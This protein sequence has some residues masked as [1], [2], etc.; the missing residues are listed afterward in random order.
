MQVGIVALGSVLALL[1]LFGCGAGQG[2]G[3]SGGGG[4]DGDPWG[5]PC[6]PFEEQWPSFSGY[7]V[8]QVTVLESDP[9][10]GTGVCL[11]N[12]F[13]GRVSCPYGQSLADLSLPPDDPRRCRIPDAAGWATEG[14]VE[15]EALPQ[16]LDR[17]AEDVV[18]CSCRCAGPDPSADYC[19]CPSGMECVEVA[20]DL[21]FQRGYEGSYCIAAGTTY[22]SSAVGTITCDK[23]D[24]DPATLCGK[25]RSNP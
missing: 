22:D 3:D 1:A 17:R 2:G 9:A 6:L 15:A 25:S 5:T 18:Q 14:A 24:T 20:P 11:V 21:G 16:L 19:T 4:T 12:H 8:E 10:C 13:Q 23:D 7:N